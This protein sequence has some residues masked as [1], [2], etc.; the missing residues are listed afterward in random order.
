[1]TVVCFHNV[2]LKTPNILECQATDHNTAI[3][4]TTRSARSDTPQD[5]VDQNQQRDNNS[6]VYIGK[7]FPLIIGYGFV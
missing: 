4:P 5:P 6:I 7:Y 3:T 1:M 2:Q